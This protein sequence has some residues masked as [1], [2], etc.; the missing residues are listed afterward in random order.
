MPAL[1]H[2]QGF[3]F[4]CDSCYQ[5]VADLAHRATMVNHAPVRKGSIHCAASTTSGVVASEPWE[6]GAH[7]VVNRQLLQ[8]LYAAHATVCRSER[9]CFCQIVA[10]HTVLLH[11]AEQP[12]CCAWTAAIHGLAPGRCMRHCLRTAR[13]P[14]TQ[15]GQEWSPSSVVE[16]S[17]TAKWLDRPCEVYSL[18]F[19]QDQVSVYASGL[20]ITRRKSRRIQSSARECH[21]VGTLVV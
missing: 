2:R 11:S 10:R 12:A 1:P 5:A 8:V 21:G 14:G 6:S 16:P 7:C 4:A 13:N 9:P 17:N 20:S 3:T 15:F 18:A 19:S